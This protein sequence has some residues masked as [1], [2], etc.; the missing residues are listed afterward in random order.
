[1]GK[2]TQYPVNSRPTT[3]CLSI[4]L[5]NTEIRIIKK[6]YKQKCLKSSKF[7]GK[8]T[9]YHQ[10]LGRCLSSTK[11]YKD[12]FDKEN[13]QTKLLKILEMYR[14]KMYAQYPVNSLPTTWCLLI[15]LNNREIRLIKKLYKQKLL[16]ILEFIG[17]VTQYV[18]NS[19]RTIWCLSSTVE[20]RN[21]FTKV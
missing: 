17:K 15:A 18:V 10:Q 3:F 21:L 9:Q 16:K 1:M 4:A 5:N 19:L 12:L 8:V 11:Q 13:L 14:G 20:C 2:V 6:L 7:I